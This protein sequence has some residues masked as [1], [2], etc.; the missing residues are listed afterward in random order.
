MHVLIERKPEDGCET[1]DVCCRVSNYDNEGGCG[2]T[3]RSSRRV[4]PSPPSG[5]SGKSSPSGTPPGNI[6]S[7]VGPRCT[8]TKRRRK[9]KGQW[10]NQLHQGLCMMCGK[11]TTQVCSLCRDDDHI[12]EPRTYICK[13]STVNTRNCFANHMMIAHH[14]GKDED[15]L[16]EIEEAV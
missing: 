2:N 11:K 16:D 14:Y 13:P 1:Q 12:P 3:P 6:T 8:P 5:S 15:D 7:A 4:V 9:H 10:T